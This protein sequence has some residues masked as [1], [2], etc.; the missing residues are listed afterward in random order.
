[1][2]PTAHEMRPRQMM[3]L[4]KLPCEEKAD[5]LEKIVILYSNYFTQ[6]R[7]AREALETSIDNLIT[8][9]NKDEEDIELRT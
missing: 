2:A 7:L 1:M 3:L 9:K 8:G 5:K 6:C 4:S